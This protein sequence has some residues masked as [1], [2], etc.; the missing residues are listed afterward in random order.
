MPKTKYLISIV[1]PTAIG[2]TALSI[3][4]AKYFKT[5]II[6]ADSR[7][8]FKEMKIGTAVPRIE[9]LEAVKHHF[10]HHKSIEDDYSVGTFEKDAISLLDELF[11]TKD[12]MVMVGGSGLYVDAVINGLDEFPH[13]DPSIRATLNQ[14][15]QSDGIEKLQNQ[16]E[17]VDKISYNSIS[18]DNPHRLVRALEVSIGTGKPFSSFLNKGKTIRKFKTITIGLTAERV[19]IYDRINQRVDIMLKEGL[20]EEVSSLISKQK[21]NALN[22]VG[23][24]E[25]FHYLNGDCTLEFAISEIKKNTR[26]YAKRQLT[27]FKR[28]EET[29]WFDVGVDFNS[30]ILEIEGKIQSRQT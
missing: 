22:T 29:I 13:I 28:N 5:E 4:L 25:L 10:I 7:Q 23:Y 9:E 1:G 30:I 24:K 19:L 11:L 17:L 27:W 21:L 26:R 6:S 3:E 20:L 14:Q 8:F 18:I 12:V 16:L 15:L 2:K